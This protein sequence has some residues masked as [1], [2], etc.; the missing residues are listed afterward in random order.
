MVPTPDV[1]RRFG[2]SRSVRLGD[3]DAD[4]L[5]RFDAIARYCQDIA[6][7]DSHDVA[8]ENADSWVVRRMAIE[9]HAAPAFREPLTLV[10]FCSGI[11]RRWA[12]RRTSIRGDD[13]GRVEVSALWVHL[14]PVSGMPIRFGDGFFDLYETA[15]QGR[16]I[17]SRLQHDEAVA[18]TATATA[19][20]VRATD[21]DLLD[22]VNNAV[23]WAIVEEW[24]VGRERSAIRA[25]VEYREPLSRS[26]EPMLW[27]QELGSG[28][29]LWLVDGTTR[30][31]AQIRRLT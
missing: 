25:E 9:I 5:L 14:D 4:G 28:A 30:A 20:P 11:G 12:E 17:S 19:W 8:L 3:T 24:L 27:C 6:N 23:Y 7:D 1:G 26:S 13:G 18:E 15:A 31:T 2:G 16:V 22:H 29:D 21:L 10:T